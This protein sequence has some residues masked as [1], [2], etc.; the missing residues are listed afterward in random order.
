MGLISSKMTALPSNFAVGVAGVT[1]GFATRRMY[2]RPL[3][4]RVKK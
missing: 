4:A 2:E 3:C 1:V